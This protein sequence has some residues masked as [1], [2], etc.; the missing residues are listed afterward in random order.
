MSLNI[1]QSFIT[2]MHTRN[3]IQQLNDE[4]LSVMHVPVL[5]ASFLPR[6]HFGENRKLVGYRCWLIKA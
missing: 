6:L 4:F 3:V 1:S 5:F 2:S